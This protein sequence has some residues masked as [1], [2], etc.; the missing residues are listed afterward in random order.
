MMRY[1]EDIE[2]R[3]TGRHKMCMRLSDNVK[4]KKILNIGCWIGWYE[5][6]ATENG[7]KSIVGLD[8]DFKSLQKARKSVNK[9]DLY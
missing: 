3:L 8:T 7:C 2:T 9:A 5:E 1:K 6:F 4:G